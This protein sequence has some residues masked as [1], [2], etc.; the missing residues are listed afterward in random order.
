MPSFVLVLLLSESA[1]ADERY[2]YSIRYGSS[3]IV[4]IE[5]V[6]VLSIAVLML[7]LEFRFT[8]TKL[9]TFAWAVGHPSS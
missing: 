2:S 7:V 9:T 3:F 5:T 4:L 6:L 1:Q 8:L